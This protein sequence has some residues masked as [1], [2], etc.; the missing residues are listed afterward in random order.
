MVS[1]SKSGERLH[2]ALH[3]NTITSQ[4]LQA[5]TRMALMYH[6][7]MPTRGIWWWHTRICDSIIT[8]NITNL[9]SCTFPMSYCQLFL[10]YV[11]MIFFVYS[12][13]WLNELDRPHISTIYPSLTF[14][15]FNISTLFEFSKSS[16]MLLM[17]FN[18]WTMF[19]KLISYPS[20]Q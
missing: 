20:K 3:F 15:T 18:I 16:E 1:L 2:N 10:S 13:T 9:V 5:L 4:L 7:V 17:I 11:W 8:P 19:P 12:L 6:K 14:I